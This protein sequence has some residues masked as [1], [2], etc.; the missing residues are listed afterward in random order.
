M[1][2]NSICPFVI[3]K[4][5]SVTRTSWELTEKN[6]A[7][8]TEM[9]KPSD[10][11]KKAP[12]NGQRTT[13]LSP[14]GIDLLRNSRWSAHPRTVAMFR[15]WETRPSASVGRTKPAQRSLSGLGHVRCTW[16]R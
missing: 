6:L 7:P 2:Q 12:G 14:Q 1:T 11:Q 5:L 13:R 15:D 9:T 8:S 3:A 10:R 4:V 16:G